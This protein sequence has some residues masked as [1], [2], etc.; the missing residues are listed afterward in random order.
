MKKQIPNIFFVIFL[1]MEHRK[2]TKILIL[3]QT[4]SPESLFLKGCD[5]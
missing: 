1:I 3:Y 4:V 2:N 5:P